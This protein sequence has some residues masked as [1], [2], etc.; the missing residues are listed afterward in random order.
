MKTIAVDC[1]F[2]STNGGLGRYTRE[3]V[4]ALAAR[5]AD[6]RYVLLVRDPEEPW[7]PQDLSVTVTQAAID[8]YSLAEQMQ[9]PAILRSTGADL[10]FSPHFNVPLR[11]PIPFVATVHDLILHRYPNHAS[12]FKRIAYRVVMKHA[13]MQSRS[14][15]C[16]SRFVESEIAS[17]YGSNVQ[18]KIR[19]I[20]EGVDAVYRPAS[21]EEQ[22][23]AREKYSLRR[24]FFLYVGN[25]KQHKNVALLM[26]AFQQSHR[27][28][29]DLV[30][31]T[32][33]KE[34]LQLPFAGPS[35]KFLSHVSD[36]DLASLFSAA[37]SFVTASLYEGF[38]L[39]IAE[40][41]ACGCPVIACNGSAITELAAGRALLLE[42]SVDVFA[43]AFRHPP[44][45]PEPVRIATWERIAK[46]V[47][48]VLID[49]L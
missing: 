48:R 2:A 15:I 26:D 11:C 47:E 38:C 1:R 13:V 37:E 44:E 43:E 39:P 19:T 4:R 7:I 25:A 9:M 18:K 3:L 21:E 20:G 10:L 34:F 36:I 31:V 27:N 45:R 16:V 28:D 30:L 40:A 22:R 14:I 24:P 5:A 23:A 35:I 6:L 42:P 46:E 29:A 12:F 33:G 17:I 49:A 32:G 41:L 8:H